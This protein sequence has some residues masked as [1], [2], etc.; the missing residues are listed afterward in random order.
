MKSAFSRNI[1]VYVK[2][3]S[4]GH[5]RNEKH[6]AVWL[7]KFWIYFI[8]MVNKKQIFTNSVKIKFATYNIDFK[9]FRV[10]IFY[11]FREPICFTF[12]VTFSQIVSIFTFGVDIF[13]HLFTFSHIDAF[14]H[15]RVPQT[16]PFVMLWYMTVRLIGSYTSACES[17]CLS[18]IPLG[19]EMY[20]AL[21]S[22]WHDQS[23]QYMF[24]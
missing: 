3:H 18:F 21:I 9:T 10:K 12:R 11:T 2:G 1:S 8:L 17:S 14:S 16:P 5:R 4:Q 7:K 6:T 22:D 19:S 13:S 20:I 23:A 24:S 15:L